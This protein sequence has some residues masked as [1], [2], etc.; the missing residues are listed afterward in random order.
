[1]MLHPGIIALLAGSG[2]N[3]IIL[4]SAAILGLKILLEW[5]I[6]D[7]SEGQFAL[8][9]KTYLVSTLVQYGL[10]FEIISFFLFIYTADDLHNLL[11]GAMCATGSLNANPYGFPALFVRIFALFLSSFWIA[12]NYLDNKAEDYPLIRKKYVLLM[13]MAPVATAGYFL[14]VKYFIGIDPNVITSCCGVLFSEGRSGIGSSLASLPA[15]QMR[16]IFYGSFLFLAFSGLSALKAR[17]KFFLYTFSAVSALFFLISILSV[18][19]FISLYFYRIPTHHCPFDILQREYYY[20]GYPLYFSLFT[21]SLFGA[22]VAVIDSFK[23]I[24]SLSSIIPNI[25]R[26]WILIALCSFTIFVIISSFPIIF[27]SFT[28][29]GY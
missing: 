11:T 16:Y 12:M 29:K 18:V 17:A 22:M 6:L 27:S 21:G 3:L 26:I 2:I 23:K 10:F 28:L 5:D 24:P 19:S 4:G 14:Q 20:A 13:L 9:K 8:E 7:S 15:N 1:M 25:Q